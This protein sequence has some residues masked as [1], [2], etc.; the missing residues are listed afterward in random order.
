MDTLAIGGWHVAHP[1]FGGAMRSM[2]TAFAVTLLAAPPQHFD[3]N[4]A[5]IGW[6]NASGMA[7]CL[8]HNWPLG[9]GMWPMQV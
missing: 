9:I 3:Q 8:G 6:P 5:K 1:M 7:C 4:Q 2:H